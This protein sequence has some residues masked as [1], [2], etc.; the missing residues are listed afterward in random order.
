MQGLGSG[1]ISVRE[2]LLALALAFVWDR[3]GGEP[4]AAVH[5]VVWLGRLIG[6]LARAAGRGAPSRDLV[7]GL[8]IAVIVPLL[9]WW[10]TRVVL[11]GLGETP[12][13]RLAVS[14][15]LLKSTFAL[16]GLGKAAL[17]VHDAIE[18]GDLPAA[19]VGLRSLCSRDASALDEAELAAAAIESVAENASDSV[20]APLFFYV[21]FGLPGAMAYRAANTADA[22][23][24]YRGAYEYL[25]KAAARLD[26]LLNVIPARLTAAL[27]LAAGA[28]HGCDVRAGWRI[29]RRD[30]G[31]TESPNAGR[32]MATMAGLL[33]VRLEKSGCYALGDPGRPVDAPLIRRAVRVVRTAGLIALAVAAQGMV[34]LAR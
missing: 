1:L 28:V 21:L 30:G 7:C 18:A 26:D 10:L 16:Q 23:I 34:W 29:W 22:M 25:G 4:P 12:W 33:G 27:L 9:G 31:K 24:G 8:G 17:V 6:A 15:W 11:L 19:R 20:V 14:V 2:Q 32:P 5:P 13:L 3:L